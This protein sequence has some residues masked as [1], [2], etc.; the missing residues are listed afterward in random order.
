MTKQTVSQEEVQDL[1]AKAW[2]DLKTHGWRQGDYYTVTDW[3][4]NQ[5]L[6]QGCSSCALGAIYRATGQ[7]FDD[8]SHNEVLQ[9]AEELFGVKVGNT[10]IAQWNDHPDRTEA[11]VLAVFEELAGP[12][13]ITRAAEG[14]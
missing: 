10:I 7:T 4:T 12:E 8:A 14:Q 9:V 13:A 3:C 6:P 1:L 2:H 11:E 5:E